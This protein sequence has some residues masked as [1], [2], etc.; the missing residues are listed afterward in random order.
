LSWSV[1]AAVAAVVASGVAVAAA[2]EIRVAEASPSG[3]RQGSRCN[4]KPAE[5]AS[6][7]RPGT[8]E[9]ATAH[10]TPRYRHHAGASQQLH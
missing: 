3:R 4:G 7:N 2:H 1:V 9:L 10:D 5:I 8:R 6:R